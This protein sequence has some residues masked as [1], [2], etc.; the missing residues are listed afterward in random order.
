MSWSAAVLVLLAGLWAGGINA[1]VGSGTLVTFPVLVALGYPPLTATMSNGIGLV[2]GGVSGVLGYRRELAGQRH[3]L[4]QL[5]PASLVGG[6]VGALLLL[7]LP[8]SGFEAAVPALILLALVLVVTQPWLQRRTRARTERRTAAGEQP[9]R[10]VG[11]L[12]VAAAGLIG[13]YG[14]YFTAAQGVLLVGALGSMMLVPLQTVNGIKN[15]LSLVVNIVS[16]VVYAALGGDRIDWAV[17]GLI[18]VSSLT[19]GWLGARYGR[20]LHPNALRAVIVVLGLVALVRSVGG[21]AGWW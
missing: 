10:G 18:A 13:V 5:V 12:A 20:R 15:V 6:I 7:R 11:A 17:A 2:A 1:V 14:G 19:G 8:E 3:R 21:L 4:L 16:A 9:R